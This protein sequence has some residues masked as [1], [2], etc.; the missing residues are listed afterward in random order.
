MTRCLVLDKRVFQ[1][2]AVF[3]IHPGSFSKPLGWIRNRNEWLG[4]ITA[5]PPVAW[6]F[7]LSGNQGAGNDWPARPFQLKPATKLEPWESTNT[8]TENQPA[9][10]AKKGCSWMSW[11]STVGIS[12]YKCL[13]RPPPNVSLPSH[14]YVS[15]IPEHSTAFFFPKLWRFGSNDFPFPFRKF[16]GLC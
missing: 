1:H 11:D 2:L 12:L 15:Y 3:P 4:F 10:P 6:I 8:S 9:G 7:L 13:E 16:V 5:Q 14:S